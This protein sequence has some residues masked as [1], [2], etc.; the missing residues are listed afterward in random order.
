MQ[1]FTAQTISLL[2]MLFNIMMANAQSDTSSYKFDEF[3]ALFLQNEIKTPT[4]SEEL[5][6]INLSSRPQIDCKTYNWFIYR[7]QKEK[8][9]R[10]TVNGKYFNAQYGLLDE[11]SDTIYAL[12]Y[13]QHDDYLIFVSRTIGW[14]KTFIDLY[15]YTSTGRALSVLCLYENDPGYDTVYIS[16]KILTNEKIHYVEN[17]Y[18]TNVKIDYELQEDGILKETS[19][20]K[21]GLR[22]VVDKDGY[23]NVREKP[24]VNSKVLYTL[25]T[26]AVVLGYS[27]NRSNWIEVIRVEEG[28]DK[29]D[30]NK[31]GGYFH[32]SRTKLYW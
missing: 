1:K 7:G 6:K 17:R 30:V 16:T 2:L 3:A 27:E 25:K 29:G 26:G 28:V 31:K 23:M 13:I 9:Q 14:E 10:C 18:A 12:G 21:L 15:T 20:S 11:E 4:S 32:S 8:L 5:L 19:F 24:D 22:E